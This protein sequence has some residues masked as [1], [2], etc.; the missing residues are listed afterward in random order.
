MPV[1]L[2]SSHWLDDVLISAA[3]CWE[4]LRDSA[5]FSMK[6]MKVKTKRFMSMA[7]RRLSP[8]PD[9]FSSWRMTWSKGDERPILRPG[10]LC[11]GAD[12]LLTFALFQEPRTLKMRFLMFLVS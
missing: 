11:S 6:M 4:D 8:R 9:T 2:I 5:H 7:K 3:R 12:C 1:L 10:E